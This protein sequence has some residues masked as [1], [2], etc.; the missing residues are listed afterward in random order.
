MTL[1]FVAV[2]EISPENTVTV[3][4]IDGTNHIERQLE[5]VRCRS[6]V[7]R[8]IRN[9]RNIGECSLLTS[10]TGPNLE[11]GR[12]EGQR[13]GD[14]LSKERSADSLEAQAASYT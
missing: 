3:V 1:L 10:G 5:V 6:W 2:A 7:T 13:R 8:V 14:Y 12:A 9:D 11:G 4:I